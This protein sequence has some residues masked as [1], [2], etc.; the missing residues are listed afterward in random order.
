MTID[1]AGFRGL[2]AI[3]HRSS[4][5]HHIF[6]GGRQNRAFPFSSIRQAWYLPIAVHR[7]YDVARSTQKVLQDCESLQDI[8]ALMGMDEPYKEEMFTAARARIVQSY[9][10]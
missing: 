10:S 7:Q 4:P 2:I 5:S 6:T 1:V 8:I 3:T 9:M